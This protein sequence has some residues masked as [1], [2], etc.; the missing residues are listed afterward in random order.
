MEVQVLER[1][2]HCS[3]AEVRID[4]AWEGV[5]SSSELELADFVTTPRVAVGQVTADT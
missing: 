5:T 2:P 4:F 3:S 1:M